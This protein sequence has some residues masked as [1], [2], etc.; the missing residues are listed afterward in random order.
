L[1]S[2]ASSLKDRIGPTGSNRPEFVILEALP[3]GTPRRSFFS[4]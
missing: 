2:S 3:P 1:S 4:F